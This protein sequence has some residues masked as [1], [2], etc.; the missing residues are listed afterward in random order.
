MWLNGVGCKSFQDQSKFDLIN[1]IMLWAGN[2]WMWK[3]HLCCRFLTQPCRVWAHKYFAVFLEQTIP[4]VRTWVMLA[5]WR[6]NLRT[7][8][9]VRSTLLFFGLYNSLFFICCF[10]W[11]GIFYIIFLSS[12]TRQ[13]NSLSSDIFLD[14]FCFLFFFSFFLVEK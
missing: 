12:D 5:R 7:A 4:T 8:C 3:G 2:S 11:G 13:N 14:F 6:A 1:E 9:I 10:W